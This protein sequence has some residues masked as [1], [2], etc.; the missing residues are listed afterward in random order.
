MRVQPRIAFAIF[1][2]RSRAKA[3]NAAKTFRHL[4]PIAHRQIH[5]EFAAISHLLRHSDG[6]PFLVV[7]HDNDDW[8]IIARRRLKFGH[9]KSD[10]AIADKHDRRPLGVGKTRADA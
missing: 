4:D 5:F 7:E 10:T 1:V 6:A 2:R 9:M 8:L 3:P